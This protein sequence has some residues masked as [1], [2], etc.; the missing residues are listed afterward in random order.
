VAF[1]P[2]TGEG[3]ETAN[4]Y[5]DVAFADSYHADRGHISWDALGLSDPPAIL[6]KKQQCIVRATDYVNKRFGRR[7]RGVKQNRRQALEWPRMNAYDND[8]YSLADIDEIPRAL[9]AAIAE[10]ALRA[11]LVGELA[12]DPIPVVPR[13]DLGVEEPTVET[14]YA[15]GQV[16]RV[17]EKVDVIEETVS[18]MTPIQ[19]ASVGRNKTILSTL[20]S[21]AMIPE[22]PAADMLLEELLTSQ[23]RTVARG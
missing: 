14:T 2:E 23:R 22:Y 9:Q 8:G 10:Y 11:A 1:V 15:G 3:L 4:A 17:S 7:F 19:M 18:Y 12:P 13:Q 5:I 21:D 6:A 20:V 16:S